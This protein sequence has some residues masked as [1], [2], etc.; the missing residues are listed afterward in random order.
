MLSWAMWPET[1]VLA[2][3]A[4]FSKRKHTRCLELLQVILIRLLTNSIVNF[5]VC[6]LFLKEVVCDVTVK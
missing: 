2:S 5:R 4:G 6:S 1:R 3:C